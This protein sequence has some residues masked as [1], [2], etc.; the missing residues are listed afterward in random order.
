MVARTTRAVRATR[1]KLFH[2]DADTVAD[3]GGSC[4]SIRAG[5]NVCSDLGDLAGTVPLIQRTGN[6]AGETAVEAGQRIAVADCRRGR[7][8]VYR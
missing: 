3:S 8:I 7:R 5:G 1:G 4:G 2:V 6:I